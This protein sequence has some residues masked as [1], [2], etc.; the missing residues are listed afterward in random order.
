MKIIITMLFSMK[1]R[2]DIDFNL[3]KQYTILAFVAIISILSAFN[4]VIF[5]PG[6]PMNHEEL[7]WVYRITFYKEAI[8]N[9]DLLPLWDTESNV[10]LGSAWPA[11][12]HRIFY[13]VAGFFYLCFGEIKLS[14]VFALVTFAFVGILGVYKVSLELTGNKVHSVIIA[15][16]YPH[17]N[18]PMT[19][20]LIRNAAAEYA[21][22]C[23]VTWIVWWCINLIK[24]RDINIS[25]SVILLFVYLGHS[26][27][28]YYSVFLLAIAVFVYYLTQNI[29]FTEV[30]KPVAVAASVF[31]LLATPVVLPIMLMWDS[32]N[33]AHFGMFN[34]STQYLPV[35]HYFGGGDYQWGKTIEGLSVEIDSFI[36][37]GIVLCIVLLTALNN[38]DENSRYCSAIRR[39]INISCIRKQLVVY[40]DK[41]LLI[42]LIVSLV[43]LLFLQLP[44]SSWFYTYFPGAA[45]IQFPWRL[46]GFITILLLV[47]FVW[48]ISKLSYF[49]KNI[50]TCILIVIVG[51]T[52]LTNVNRDIGY[53]WYSENYM[54]KPLKYNW[55]EYF[56]KQER[57]QG[58]NPSI[59]ERILSLRRDIENNDCRINSLDSLNNYYER[60]YDV[61]CTH[62]NELLLPYFFTGL[63]TVEIKKSYG[64]TTMHSYKTERNLL[65]TID[66]PRGA[67]RVRYV[68]PSFKGIILY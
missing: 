59:T 2:T 42:Y 14:M 34:P 23:I 66:F 57:Y 16:V 65:V 6:W 33:M 47:L 15:A 4:I 29:S 60:Y 37:A 56:P 53:E 63:E 35:I 18:Y 68:I 27:I 24:N 36:T 38:I 26:V 55:A 51:A 13:F 21:S 67:S 20:W 25:I 19:D 30:C 49:N 40:T 44:A 54:L 22:F 1:N 48:L 5:H 7:A 9:F 39:F 41:T 50:S 32:A 64:W 12:Y 31:A 43:F 61:F 62:N 28:A 58:E 10:G 17:L 8:S 3:L 52:I 46:L 11:I 45:K